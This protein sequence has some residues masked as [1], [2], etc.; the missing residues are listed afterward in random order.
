MEAVR[1]S[2]LTWDDEMD[3]LDMAFDVRL[4]SRLSCQSHVSEEDLEIQITE[5]SLSAYMDENPALRR[6]LEAQGKWPPK[7]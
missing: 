3:R 6:E 4:I 7:K 5:E 1:R 2:T